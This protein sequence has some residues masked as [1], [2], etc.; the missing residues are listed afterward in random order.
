M[1][2]TVLA[3]ITAMAKA[4]VAG[5][6]KTRLAPAL[7]EDGAAVLAA[8]MLDHAV[9]QAVDAKLGPV[10]VSAAPDAAHPAFQRLRRRYG[11]TLSVQAGGDLGA[12][13]A[14]VFAE[15]FAQD[16]NTPILVI[17]TDAPALDGA[18]LRAAAQA[19]R[20]HDAV[21]VPALDGGYALIG[22]RAPA[23]ALFEDM[24]WSTS[25]VMADTRVRLATA[26]L[27]HV[28]LPA[29]ADIDEPADL[30]HLPP[31]WL[32]FRPIRDPSTCG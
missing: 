5:L 19:L 32:P 21:L 17:G 30:Q 16:S 12:R 2:R 3:R 31:G 20:D 15:G 1:T 25:R 9:A 14:H 27:T 22:L 7:G 13:L 24:R 4:P 23:S 29:V 6:A 28:E 11:V 18:V 8:R 10:T 26:G